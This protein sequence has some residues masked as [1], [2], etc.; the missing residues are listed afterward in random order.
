MS[1]CN[2][3]DLQT[4]GSQPIMP[5]NFPDHCLETRDQFHE[6]CNYIVHPKLRN[7]NLHNVT[8]SLI[9]QNPKERMFV[10]QISLLIVTFS[11]LIS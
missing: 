7:I 8:H 3:L 6:E 2:R 11:S 9:S 10:C 1:T 4:L 5:E